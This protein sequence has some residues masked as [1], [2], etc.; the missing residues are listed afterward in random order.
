MR[1]I[2]FLL[3]FIMIINV[4]KAQDIFPITVTS[5]GISASEDASL[6]VKAQEAFVS[7]V[8][9][10]VRDILANISTSIEGET[11]VD[12][13]GEIISDI[14]TSTTE[15]KIGDFKVDAQTSVVDFE[16]V[17]DIVKCDFNDEKIVILKGK[18]VYPPINMLKFPEFKPF[19]KKISDIQLKYVS[20]SM[21][22]PS[23]ELQLCI[24]LEYLYD[25]SVQIDASSRNISSPVSFR[26]ITDR[27]GDYIFKSVKIDGTSF[28]GE[29]DTP[30]LIQ[31]KAYDDACRNAIEYVNG[32][33]IKSLT[34]TKNAM[35]TKDEIISKTLGIA[36]VLDKNFQ[37]KFSS[38]GNFEIICTITT[39]IP[40]MEIL[41]E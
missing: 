23:G 36:H 15:G 14:I 39:N 31:D 12:D 8:I 27:N 1:T 37:S 29:D 41:A 19:P 34:E 11:Q 9:A 24:E 22:K 25:P 33:F 40:I 7:A 13:K 18:L 35:L 5:F 30:K 38:S 32:V 2:F 6:E 21:D 16:M 10:G 4:T 3:P 20:S 26:Y 28:G 17:A